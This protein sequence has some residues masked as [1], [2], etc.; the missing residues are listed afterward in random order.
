MLK[1]PVKHLYKN[2]KNGSEKQKMSDNIRESISALLDNEASEIEIHRVVRKFGDDPQLR[3]SLLAWQQIRAVA[4]NDTLLSRQ[5]HVTLLQ[6]IRTELDNETD[7]L[8]PASR[9]QKS[10]VTFTLPMAGLAVAASLVLA[11]FVGI[12]YQTEQTETEIFAGP[13][14]EE[15]TPQPVVMGIPPDSGGSNDGQLFG[16]R[17]MTP[18]YVSVNDAD[19]ELIELDEEKRRLVKEYLLRHERM[20]GLNPDVRL[21]NFDQQ[22]SR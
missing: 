3:S 15:I 22:E 13:L 7:T 10:A 16:N 18:Q 21:V 19:G 20:T 17:G 6:R 1:K 14:G 2:G 9:S 4:K 5:T 12:Y 8:M 11:V